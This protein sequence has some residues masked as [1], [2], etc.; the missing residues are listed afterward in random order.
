MSIEQK[1]TEYRKTGF[2]NVWQ[3]DL[4]NGNFKN[5]NIHT[6]YSDPDICRDGDVFYMTASSFSNIPGLPVLRSYDLI[7]WE[8]VSYAIKELPFPEYNSPNYGCAVWAPAI[9]KHGEY[10]Y[11][12]IGFP[13]EGVF[14]TRTKDPCGEWEPLHCLKRVRGWIDT[15]PLWDDDG[16]AYMVNAFANSR[17]GFKSV[18]AVSEMTPDG[19]ELTGNFRIV[20]DG[21]VDNIDPT[22][23]GPKFYKRNGWYY[24]AAPSGGVKTGWQLVLRSRNVFGPYERK[25]TL[26]QGDSPINGPHQGGW[27][28]LDNGESWFAHFQDK[29]AYGRIVHMQPMRWVDDWPEMGVDTNNDGIGEPVMEYKKPT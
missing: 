5:P 28:D 8:L 12:F 26:H 16:K 22:I 24:I 4:G 7:N 21:N 10:F 20:Y 27:V 9:R 25:V 1:I 13:D 11:I 17:I 19:K 23:E 2:P 14:M 3:S 18:I 29:Y 6:D 15:C